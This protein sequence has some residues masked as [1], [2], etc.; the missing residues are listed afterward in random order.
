[1]FS[2]T[3]SLLRI[4]FYVALRIVAVAVKVGDR[5]G[6]L[7]SNKEHS[8]GSMRTEVYTDLDVF[9]GEMAEWSKAPD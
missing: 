3:P 7:C 6:Q 2:T 4:G 9:K 1:M 8:P 5:S